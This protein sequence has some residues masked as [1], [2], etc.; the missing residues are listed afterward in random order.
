MNRPDRDDDAR[1]AAYLKAAADPLRMRVI[2][3][4][5]AGPMSVSD[6]ALLVEQDIG[7]VSHHLRV[8][9]HAE[10]VQTRREGKFIYYSLCEHL[11]PSRKRSDSGVLDFG[12]CRLDVGQGEEGCR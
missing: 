9:Y 3:A 8:L 2:R 6:L 11:R 4:L 7:V 1:C 12:C 10:V 5:Q